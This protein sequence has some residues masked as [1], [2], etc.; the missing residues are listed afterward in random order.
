MSVPEQMSIGKDP[1]ADDTGHAP[2]NKESQRQLQM[3]WPDNRLDDP[4]AVEMPQGYGLRTYRP[5]DAEA[6]L[7]LMHK[8]G[9]DQ[10]DAATL[11]GAL[12]SVLPDGLFVIVHDATGALTATAMATHKPAA[13]HP[14]G[15][16]LG[17]LAGDLAHAGKGLGL[18]VCCAVIRR[19]I[20][21]GYTRIYL[22]TDDWRLGAIK[23]YLK[24][25]FLPFLF[26]DT[27]APRWKDICEKLTWPF[28]MDAW[29][30][31]DEESEG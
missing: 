27:M 21:A 2:A 7:E 1:Q 19:Y 31:P 17:W 8:A 23:T 25:G 22:Q 9:F 13:L 28:T 12:P 6:Y 3:L 20:K 14:F 24:M 30:V 18:A 10:W 11:E 26:D 16:E 15:G 4:P 29:C 5:S